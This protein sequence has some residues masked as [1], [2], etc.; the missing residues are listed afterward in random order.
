[1]LSR[2]VCDQLVTRPTRLMSVYVI[3]N[4]S[5]NTLHLLLVVI[6]FLFSIRKF[7]VYIYHQKY[8]VPAATHSNGNKQV[9]DQ[10]YGGSQV[11]TFTQFIQHHNDVTTTPQWHHN[12]FKLLYC[13]V[14]LL[15]LLWCCGYCCGADWIGWRLSHRADRLTLHIVSTFMFHATSSVFSLVT[16]VW[17]WIVVG[18]IALL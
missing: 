5:H 8:W 7:T 14:V 3:V 1:M 10:S 12:N 6:Y 4:P 9:M 2:K 17:C 18:V 11:T 13:I 15:L 16:I